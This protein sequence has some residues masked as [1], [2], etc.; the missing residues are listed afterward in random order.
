MAD[1]KVQHGIDDN[2]SGDAGKGAALGGVGGAAVG[3]AAGSMVGPAGTLIG[4]VVGGIAGAVS[5]GVAVAAVDKMDDDDTVSGFGD[6][7]DT[8]N[9]IENDPSFRPEARGLNQSADGTALPNTHAAMA[10][11]M[12]GGEATMATNRSGNTHL[13]TDIDEDLNVTTSD[14]RTTTG[15]HLTA[16]EGEARIP[17]IEEE[18]QVGK[19][20]VETGGV[21]VTSNV[22]EVP[23]EEQVRLRE[24][25]VTV[26]R[27]PVDRPA[28]DADLRA[29]QGAVLEVTE[30]AEEAVVAKQARVVEEV[31]VG[32]EASERTETIRDTVRH[33]D[34]DVQ[35][36]EQDFRSNFQT[37]YGHR[38]TAY[39]DHEPAY[40]FGSD[41]GSDNRY[42]NSD[43]NTVE[44]DARQSW[45]SRHSGNWDDYKDAVRYGYDR[46]RGHR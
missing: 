31:V 10:A 18:L 42:A 27:H 41:L 45:S 20:E 26:D 12:T 43:W 16:A 6:N 1:D 35:Q 22:T 34:V 28:T 9:G 17:V 32:K 39:E 3:A 4:A 8:D 23:V 44:N 25:H 5:S 7:D 14:A 37:T 24:E 46:V 30:T 40:R 19:R 21:R 29:A 2:P 33:T 13:D 36:L 38:G 15:S 11:P